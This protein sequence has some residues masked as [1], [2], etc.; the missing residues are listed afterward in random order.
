MLYKFHHF[1][2]RVLPVSLALACGGTALA[3]SLPSSPA[4]ISVSANSNGTVFIQW[5]QSY[6]SDGWIAKYELLKNNS[7][8]QV[9]NVTS[10]IDNNITS[11]ETYHYTV[12]AI[13]NN[14]DRSPASGIASATVSIGSSGSDDYPSA[15]SLPIAVCV[16]PDQDGWGWDGVESCKMDAFYSTSIETSSCF[17]VDEKGW[18]WDGENSCFVGTDGSVSFSSSSSNSNSIEICIDTDGDGYGWNGY[19]TCKP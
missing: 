4:S 9:G 17:Y 13:D 7:I 2:L 15:T 12:V 18:G 3:S 5:G 10:Y 11:G 16:D 6:D 14:G 19:D 1:Y 8:I